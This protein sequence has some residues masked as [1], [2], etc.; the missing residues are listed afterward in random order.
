MDPNDQ[1][2]PKELE[3]LSWILHE[4]HK[5]N[6]AHSLFQKN[7][8]HSKYHRGNNPT[9]TYRAEAMD[10]FS[11]KSPADFYSFKF[12]DTRRAEWNLKN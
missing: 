1:S 9:P 12:T 2:T 10:S 3:G 11:S 5:D 8:P 7:D 6:P 4:A